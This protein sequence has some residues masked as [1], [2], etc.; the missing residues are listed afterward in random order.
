MVP[1][2]VYRLAWAGGQSSIA[3]RVSRFPADCRG[4]RRGRRRAPRSC[5]ADVVGIFLACLVIRRCWRR[6]E[7][8]HPFGACSSVRGQASGSERSTSLEPGRGAWRVGGAEFRAGR[9][10]EP[11]GAGPGT[12]RAGFV[13]A[14]P[15]GGC[16]GRL[17]PQQRRSQ[18]RAGGGV[19]GA[20][21]ATAGRNSQHALHPAYRG[22]DRFGLGEGSARGAER[23]GG[24]GG[25]PAGERGSGCQPRHG[26][27]RAAR[28]PGA[29][30][31]GWRG[32][33]GRRGRVG[34]CGGN[35]RGAS[36]DHGAHA[37]R[38]GNRGAF[39]PQGRHRAGQAPERS[40]ARA[41]RARSRALGAR[42]A[43]R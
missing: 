23:V 16:R 14:A 11:R 20:R 32:R 30:G 17:Y 35:R 4:F 2:R 1:L 22:L 15:A 25:G 41:G 18:G 34:A 39:R 9:G 24:P 29:G 27:S 43:A 31:V 10:E 5:A 3:T 40:R 38:R 42:R 8:I 19:L 6:D 28:G 12:D 21:D 33:R 36:P 7:E 26:S 37:R 13:A